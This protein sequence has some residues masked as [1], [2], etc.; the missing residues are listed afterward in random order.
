MFFLLCRFI[1]L[2]SEESD[3]YLLRPNP[4]REKVFGNKT[5]F[6][7]NKAQV[8]IPRILN[9]CAF[10][11]LIYLLLKFVLRKWKSHGK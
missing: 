8:N 11:N 10:C 7:C 6:F 4:Q 2:L 5:F 1:P 9:S 3:E